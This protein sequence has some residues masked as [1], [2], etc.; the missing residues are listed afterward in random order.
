MERALHIFKIYTT[1]LI[2]RWIIYG[3]I[4]ELDKKQTNV[5]HK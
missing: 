3:F 4:D 1:T 2:Y 5:F